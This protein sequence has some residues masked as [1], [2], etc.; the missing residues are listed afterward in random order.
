MENFGR[1][2]FGSQTR[3]ISLSEILQP[4]FLFLLQLGKGNMPQLAVLVSDIYD[5][6]I[7]KPRDNQARQILKRFLVIERPGE[8]LAGISQKRETLLLGFGLG[9]CSLL[10]DQVCTLFGLAFYL[11]RLF[12][13]VDK[14]SD[15]RPQNVRDNWSENVIDCAQRVT[16]RD[17]VHR[18]VDRA[19][20]DDWCSFGARSLS[21]EGRGF[22]AVHARHVHVKQDRGEIALQQVA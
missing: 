12:E 3:S 14:H 13:E 22:E 9:A 6:Q 2:V 10:A 19:Y 18:V 1:A 7:R 8:H 21:Y 4:V 5:T 17:V 20:E 11:F 16:A 15:F